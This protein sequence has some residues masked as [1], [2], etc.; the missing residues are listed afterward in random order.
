ML[1]QILR[2]RSGCFIKTSILLDIFYF[3]LL[4]ALSIFRIV[5]TLININILKIHDFP[6]M[7]RDIL[8]QNFL[9]EPLFVHV[10][11]LD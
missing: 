3:H 1:F 2:D 11:E 7:H 8:N 6:L 10:H 5:N 4:R 9:F